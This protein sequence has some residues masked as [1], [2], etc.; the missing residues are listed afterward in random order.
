M[1][2]LVTSMVCSLFSF[3]LAVNFCSV[4][5]STVIVGGFCSSMAYAL[6]FIIL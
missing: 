1:F 3:T 6:K 2:A 5:G 4:C